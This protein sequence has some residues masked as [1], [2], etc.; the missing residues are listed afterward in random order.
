MGAPV[1][2]RTRRDINR[3]ANPDV[4]PFLDKAR[5]QPGY[6][7]DEQLR[8][9]ASDSAVLVPVLPPRFLQSDYCQKEVKG[10]IDA[11]AFPPGRPIGAASCP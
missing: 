4:Y 2:R 9:A 11:S 10:F 7:W 5:L 1:P 6:V 3:F 8:A